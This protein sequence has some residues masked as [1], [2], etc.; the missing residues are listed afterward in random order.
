ML[1]LLD[2]VKNIILFYEILYCFQNPQIALGLVVLFVY[3]SHAV[4]FFNLPEDP[5]LSIPR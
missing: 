5:W 3:F 2:F 1:Y 4:G